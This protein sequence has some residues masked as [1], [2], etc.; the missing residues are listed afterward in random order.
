MIKDIEIPK[1]LNTVELWKNNKINP[2]TKLNILIVNDSL[3]TIESK[4]TIGEDTPKLNVII[5]AKIFNLTLGVRLAIEYAK[6][7]QLPIP[8]NVCTKLIAPK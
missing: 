2:T 4:A 1:S 8:M 3:R 5:V 7:I 6:K